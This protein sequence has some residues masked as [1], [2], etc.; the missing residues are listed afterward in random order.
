RGNLVLGAGAAAEDLVQAVAAAVVARADAVLGEQVVEL[1][2]LL[3][4][5]GV[6]GLVQRHRVRLLAVLAGDGPGRG[7]VAARGVL[8]GLPRGR[9]LLARGLVAA[10]LLL[11]RGDLG[12]VDALVLR[13]DDLLLP[14]EGLVEGRRRGLLVLRGLGRGLLAPRPSRPG[15]QHQRN[16]CG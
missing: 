16:T 11:H 12:V 8:R 2:V 1:V 10:T 9:R 14:L 4:R 5:G 7:V 3:G 15:Q 6:R 13:A